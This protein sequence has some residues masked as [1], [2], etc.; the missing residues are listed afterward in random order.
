MAGAATRSGRGMSSVVRGGRAPVGARSPAGAY[1][2]IAVAVGL[3]ALIPVGVGASRT[4]MGLATEMLVFA[5]Y[6]TAFNLIFGSTGQ[7]FL[8]VGALAGV[9]G[10]GSA[11]LA[12]SAGLPVLLTVPLATV[13][14]SL[15]GALFSWVSARRS[16][17]VI[18]VGIVTL[19]FSLGF[20]NLLLGVRDVTGGETGLVVRA[21]SESPLGEPVPAYY[22][23]LAVLAGYLVVFRRLQRSHVGWAFRALS[24]D[25]TAAELAGV[26]VARYRILAGLI[27]SAMLGL[28]G[29]LFAHHQGFV[30]PSTFAFGHVDV[31]TLV[32]LAL[33]G[34]GT[35]LGPVIGA[36]ILELID[37]LLRDTGRLRIAVYGV[38][39]VAL[40]LGFRGGVGPAVV[41]LYR[42]MT[43]GRGA[44]S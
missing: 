23:F 38:V 15:I 17:D 44:G 27:G 16:L 11:L 22:V 19:T 33:G 18:F 4:Y 32:V 21:G 29:A 30:S 25:E 8:C 10:Y 9:A 39:L 3:L 14:S 40:F 2:P 1:A 41:S 28:L 31:R 24:D 5:G 36:A 20:A 37:E 34:I 43:S 35:L 13:A 7:L 42:R 12:D 26:D 6:A